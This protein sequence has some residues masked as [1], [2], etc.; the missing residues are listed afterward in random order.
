MPS[1]LDTGAQSHEPWHETWP[2]DGQ[3]SVTNCPVCGHA[4][5][6]I[7][8]TGL[9]DTA[10]RTAPG[11]WSLWKCSRCHSAYLD[12]RP[13]LDTIHKAYANY[14]T[15]KI[16]SQPNSGNHENSSPLRKLRRRLV[17]GYVNWR[18]GTDMMPA[19]SIGTLIA[20]AFP[21][22][23]NSLDRKYRHLPKPLEHRGVL[24][25]VGCGDGSF[26]QL[27][28]GIG[29]EAVGLDLDP[30]VVTNAI[31]QGLT[32][33]HG[34]IEYFA[35]QTSLFDVITLNHVIEHVHDPVRLLK[36][37]YA[38]LKNGGQVWVQTPNI[39]SFGHAR[40]QEYW[41]GLE[42][43][44]HIVLFNRNSLHQAF[45]SAGFDEPCDLVCPSECWDMYRKS[46]AMEQ[47]HS[48]YELI[49]LP[50]SV[51]AEAIKA[52]IAEKI[53]PLK[54]EFLTVSAVKKRL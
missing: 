48:P 23:R 16:K 17:N 5:R 9:I 7:L 46:F 43:P 31:D 8:H 47:G 45:I 30:K 36:A 25:D 15:H 22:L 24:L 41:R 14:Y 26:L 20:F 34:S 49:E 1:Q 2:L 13:T 44:R 53:F 42:P 6:D 37:C 19:S 21:H 18:F 52:T 29:W 32:V 50:A 35:D 27:A 28:Q 4:R 33:Y 54:R 3:E 39:D 40:F 11:N 51:K 38:L 10:F 12:P